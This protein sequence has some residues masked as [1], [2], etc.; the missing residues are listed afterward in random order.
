MMIHCNDH[1]YCNVVTQMTA[2]AG[3]DSWRCSSCHMMNDQGDDFCDGCLA[4]R[5]VTSE[6]VSKVDP[7][8]GNQT[9]SGHRLVRWSVKWTPQQVTKPPQAT[10][11]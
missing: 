3:T 5:P 11:L 9:P 6:V 4:D 10:D 1:I 8:A 2:V 7:T